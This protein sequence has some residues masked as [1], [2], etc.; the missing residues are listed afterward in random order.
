MS[1]W[2]RYL[3]SS[4]KSPQILWKQFMCYRRRCSMRD[5][6]WPMIFTMKMHWP[7]IFIMKMH[8]P[9]IFYLGNASTNVFLLE[10]CIGQWFLLWSCENSSLSLQFPSCI[11]NSNCSRK[12]IT[13]DNINCPWDTLASLSASSNIGSLKYTSSNIPA[14]SFSIIIRGNF[15]WR[16]AK[17]KPSLSIS[18]RKFFISPNMIRRSGTNI[19][20]QFNERKRLNRHSSQAL[21]LLLTAT[22]VRHKVCRPTACPKDTENINIPCTHIGPQGSVQNS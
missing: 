11:P 21:T 1:L 3:C 5:M 17:P 13:T 18:V 19:F 7:M 22:H 6:H 12:F 4:I 9:M 20:I 16:K 15:S 10:K 8:W 2:K 14:L